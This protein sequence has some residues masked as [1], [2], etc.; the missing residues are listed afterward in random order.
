[1]NI[2]FVLYHD[3]TANSASHV[4]CLAHELTKLGHDCSVAVPDNKESVANLGSVQFHPLEFRDALLYGCSFTNGNG[5]DVI[6]AWTPREIVRR[7]CER[8][9]ARYQCPLFVHMEDNEWHILSCA[10]GRPFE[11]L[12][13]QTTEELDRIV[14]PA[15]SHPHRARQFLSEARGI[16][17]I[18]DRLRDLIPPHRATLE[19]WPSADETLFHPRPKFASRRRALGIPVNSTV[20]VYTGNVHGANA[21]EM[22]SLYLAVALLNRQG[23]PATL[24]R[25][26][27]DFYPFLGV[28]ERWGRQYSIELGMVPHTAVPALLALADVLVQPGAADAFNDFRFPSKLPEFLSAGRPVVLPNSNIGKQMKHGRHAFVLSESNAVT[29]AD[30]V[31]KIMSDPVLSDRLAAGAFEFFSERLSWASSAAKLN[32]FYEAEIDAENVRA[33]GSMYEW[34]GVGQG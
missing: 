3:F 25:A 17:I 6:H 9:I 30:A 11:R 27:R 28:D 19:L 18:I 7:F 34:S 31:H 15:L 8:L 32:A 13:S 22:R 10:L 16:T 24:V 14:T 33:A 12:A 26:G 29:I 1:V 20:I 2:L 5:P 21:H 4:R 23:H